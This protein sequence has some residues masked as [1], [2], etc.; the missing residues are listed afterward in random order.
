MVFPVQQAVA[1]N[2]QQ[3][4]KQALKSDPTFKAALS[5]QMS[6]AEKVPQ[7][8]AILLPQINLLGDLDFKRRDID[9]NSDAGLATYGSVAH[10]SENS[11]THHF[12]L[13]LT[14]TIFNFSNWEKLCSAKNTVKASKATYNAAAQD[15]M[16]RTVRSYLAILEAK[17]FLR[18][19]GA[20]KRAFYQEYLRAEQSFKV[21]TKTITDVYNAKAAYDGSVADYVT[22]Q[23]DLADKRED[24]RSITGILYKN[25]APLKKTIPLI[26]P[27][28]NNSD[29]WVNIATQQNWKLVA[30]RYTTLST[31]QNIKVARGGHLPT[32]ELNTSYDNAYQ[33]TYGYGRDRITAATA[34]ADI[35]L[36]IFQGGIVNSE[37]RQ[38]IA[39][40]EKASNQQEETYRSALNN[41]RKSFLGVISGISTIKANSQAVISSQSSLEGTQ[42]GYQVGTRTMIDVLLA[43]KQL[44]DI[45]KQYA[46]SRYKY[47]VSIT[48]L[49]EAAG[50]LSGNDIQ[51]INSWLSSYTPKIRGRSSSRHTPKKTKNKKTP[52]TTTI[53]TYLQVGTYSKQ[54][55]AKNMVAQIKDTTKLPCEIYPAQYG[56]TKL[57]AVRI[58]P[59]NDKETLDKLSAKLKTLGITKPLIIKK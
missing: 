3:V 25:L 32:L 18:F 33:R 50:T 1:A 43:Q 56:T 58:G 28:P 7:S 2:L 12:N 34:G 35:S 14:Q 45:Q 51:I 46:S 4:Y 54:E 20:E 26:V 6:E 23:N 31:H 11:R 41:T 30:A 57:Y 42:V 8:L 52:S 10:R 21:G 38:A 29:K 17:D 40:Y 13:G 59:I 5:Q 49:K 37:T 9:D 15:L 24:L 53:K 47:I 22:A 19:T 36:P 16:S 44:Y 39:L 48:D 55:H 27:K